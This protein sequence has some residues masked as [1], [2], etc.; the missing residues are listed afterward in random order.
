MS[1]NIMDSIQEF[2]S[3]SLNWFQIKNGEGEIR[4][5]RVSQPFWRGGDKTKFLE[6]ITW[7]Y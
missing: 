5:C 3:Q 7:S 1:Q 6:N 4:W 2:P